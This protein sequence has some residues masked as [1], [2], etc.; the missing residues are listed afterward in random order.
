[1][2][3]YMICDSYFP[4]LV[5]RRQDV[6]LCLRDLLLLNSHPE[7]KSFGRVGEGA[8]DPQGHVQIMFQFIFQEMNQQQ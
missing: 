4:K 6:S 3:S 7:D 2:Y 5:F 8:Y 1:M